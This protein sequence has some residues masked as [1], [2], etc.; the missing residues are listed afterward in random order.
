MG[1]RDSLIER[2]RQNFGGEAR[3]YR[4]PG[5]VNLI[6]EH[7]DY[8][9]GFVLPAALQQCTWIA[10]AARPEL[11][12]RVSS[13]RAGE[14]LE[15]ALDDSDPRPRR[16]W[17]DYVRG[18]AIMLQR[19]GYRLS[20]ADMLID[21]DVPVGSGLSSSAALEVASGFALLDCA[22]QAID[23]TRLALDCQRAENEFVGMRCGVMD[24]FAS[25]RGAADRVLLLDC[26]S[27]EFRLSPVDP[28][29]RLVI[30]NSM[31]H[32][33]LAGSEYN[34]RREQCEDGVARLKT[35]LPDIRA[36]RDVTADNL[37]RH[38]AL[39]SELVLRRCRHVVTENDRVERAAVAL[40][41]GKVAEVG[42]LMNA[43]HVSMR[44][45]YEISCREIDVLVELA[46]RVDGVLGARMT[47]GGFGGCTINLVRVEAVDRFADE[48]GRGYKQAT[49]ITPQFLVCRPGAGVGAAK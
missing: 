46:G 39:L 43:S 27:L 45:D 13:L 6:G 26:R 4:A 19:D 28:S 25:C 21:S 32:H 35:V 30:C 20:G 8:N 14:T 12:L 23:L 7:T 29:V 22:G 24:Q 44:D 33:E 37:A 38:G 48:V 41:A 36:L 40:E 15:F 42:R 2:F 10:A 47:G 31:V 34:R 11:R 16:D 3:L 9:D 1:A 5:R 49:G 17:S 18:V